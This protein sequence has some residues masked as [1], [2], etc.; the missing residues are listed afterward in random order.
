MK[1]EKIGQ[2]KSGMENN[3]DDIRPI[4]THTQVCIYIL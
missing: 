3:Q 1:K 2:N 4:S